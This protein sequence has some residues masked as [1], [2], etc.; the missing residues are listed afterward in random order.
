M[1]SIPCPQANNAFYELRFES[2]APHVPVLVF[3]CDAHG[4]V[5]LDSLSQ[6]ALND[7]LFARRGA[8]RGLFRQAITKT[9]NTLA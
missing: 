4:E 5:N 7:Y 1:N 3:P 2:I 8:H 6:D 9:H